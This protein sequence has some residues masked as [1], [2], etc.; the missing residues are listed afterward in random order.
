MTAITADPQRRPVVIGHSGR[1]YLLAPNALY[2][3]GDW[4]RAI[5]YWL[6]W[7]TRTRPDNAPERAD[8][9]AL[10]DARAELTVEDTP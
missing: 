10:L 8:I 7:I 3:V 9:D 1:P 4:I 2:E 5:D 6:H